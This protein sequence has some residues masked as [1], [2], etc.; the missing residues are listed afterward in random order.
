MMPGCPTPPGTTPPRSAFSSCG[1]PSRNEGPHGS[2]LR[3]ARE[4]FR[5]DCCSAFRRAAKLEMCCRAA[6]PALARC[7]IADT[8]AALPKG[9][10]MKKVVLAF[11]AAYLA[12]SSL[13]LSSLVLSCA[14]ASAQ[15][16]LK[17]VTSWVGSVHGPY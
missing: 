8:L 2:S 11:A 6:G 4:P 10:I 1:L 15:A 13:V 3:D 7:A 9:S 5:W 17:W 16:P 12:L 14:I